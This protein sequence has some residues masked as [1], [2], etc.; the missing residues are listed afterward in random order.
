MQPLSQS[1]KRSS[2]NIRS[3]L[4]YAF[5]RVMAVVSILG[6]CLGMAVGCLAQKG[7]EAEVAAPSGFSVSVLSRGKGVPQKALQVLQES[8]R[9][10]EHAQTQ[11]DVTRLVTQRIG[12]EGEARLCAEFSNHQVEARLFQRVQQLSSAVD[13]VN[14]KKE[15]CPP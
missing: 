14:V 10:L 9:L 1:R 6:F 4:L 8:R 12:L 5:H 3:T 7:Y 2:W 15:I 13:L 11:G